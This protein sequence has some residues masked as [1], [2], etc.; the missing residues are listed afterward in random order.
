MDM[1]IKK[2]SLL[3]RAMHGDMVASGVVSVG[4]VVD[5]IP[6]ETFEEFIMVN[7]FRLYEEVVR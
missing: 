5:L 6:A 3:Y 7:R 1:T 2:A 4:E